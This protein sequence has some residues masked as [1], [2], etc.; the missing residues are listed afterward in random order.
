MINRTI[1][2]RAQGHGRPVGAYIHNVGAR[3]QN[4]GGNQGVGNDEDRWEL[5]K[6]QQQQNEL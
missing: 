5:I 4:V 2:E 1:D 3:A 6:Y